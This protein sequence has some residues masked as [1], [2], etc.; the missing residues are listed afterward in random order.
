MPLGVHGVTTTTLVFGPKPVAVG[1]SVAPVTSLLENLTNRHSRNS[2]YREILLYLESNLLN[3][4][5]GHCPI[6]VQVR[7]DE[8]PDVG[9]YMAV[10]TENVHP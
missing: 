3:E 1:A 9:I 6:P 8:I 7:L 10:R 5:R 4:T 2:P